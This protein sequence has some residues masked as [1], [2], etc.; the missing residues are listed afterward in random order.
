MPEF[1]TCDCGARIRLPEDRKGQQF[2]CPK[3]KLPLA[4]TANATVLSTTALPPGQDLH[5]SICR[6]PMS[7]HDPCVT[8]PGCDQVYHRECWSEI[9]GCG[10]YGCPESPAVDK[11]E[12][13][14]RAPLTAWGDTKRCPGC[15]EQIKAI[16][17]RCRYCGTEFQSVDPMSVAD[18]RKQAVTSDNI[19][20][21]KKSITALFVVSLVGCFAPLMALIGL[22][23]LL[24]RRNLLSRCGPVYQVMAWTAVALSCLYS[25][26][27]V[28]FLLFDTL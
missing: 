18:L 4:L 12:T 13:S 1:V 14:A 19:E 24:P 7:E 20:L 11:S 25:L 23:Y 6:T 21:I 27:I 15:G 3:C 2:R 28:A 5:C 22:V 10:T 26:L 8:C 16:A 9:G 17:L